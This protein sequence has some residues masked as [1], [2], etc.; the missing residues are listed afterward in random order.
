MHDKCGTPECCMQCQPDLFP[1]T[2]STA[3][4]HPNR[5]QTS[6]GEAVYEELS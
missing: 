1:E 5:K 4:V 2:L 6:D 3:V